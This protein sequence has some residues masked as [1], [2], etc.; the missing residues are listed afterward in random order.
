MEISEH[1]NLS[2]VSLS[3][4]QAVAINSFQF[5]DFQKD[6]D[7]KPDHSRVIR[8]SPGRETGVY[9]LEANSIIGAT[10]IAGVP[11][12]ILPKVGAVKTAQM[13]AYSLGLVRFL[14]TASSFAASSLPALLA[15]GFLAQAEVIVRQGLMEDYVHIVETGTRPRGRIDFRSLSKNGIPLPIEYE[16]DDL[17]VD[18]ELNRLLARTL[19]AIIDIQQLPGVFRTKARDLLSAFDG[20]S[21][22]EQPT[23]YDGSGVPV[24][25]EQYRPAIVLGSLILK[26]SGIELGSSRVNANGILFDMNK[27]V[28]DF[29][30]AMIRR[31]IPD[32]LLV[33]SQGRDRP[34]YLAEGK[35][36][37]IKPDFAIWDQN[38]CLIVGDI[39]YKTLDKKNGPRRSDI[40]QMISYA[41]TTGAHRALLVYIGKGSGSIIE[42]IS[43]KLT[44][45]IRTVDLRLEISEIEEQVKSLLNLRDS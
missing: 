5:S 10:T 18:T 30:T 14:D 38:S 39:K 28:E 26:G 44:I 4:S 3:A 40:Y 45:E 31:S 37:R 16:F 33:D 2:N 42:V 8:V 7:D 36:F 35:K 1:G 23:L 17:I 43:P 27:V 20:V 12:T 41:A 21:F 25:M 15:P 34:R 24:R 22:V 29:V 13:L 9:T 19:Y 32:C 11:I 6:G